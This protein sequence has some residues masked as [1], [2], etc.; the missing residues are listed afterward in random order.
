MK[1][2][3]AVILSTIILFY[4]FLMS[5]ITMDAAT[6]DPKTLQLNKGI[7]TIPIELGETHLFNFTAPETGYY[8]IETGGSAD[9][10]GKI[11]F[12]GV[13]LASDDDSG[14][15]MNC[16]ISYTASD[17]LNTLADSTVPKNILQ[18]M[19]YD[20]SVRENFLPNDALNAVQAGKK[21]G[22]SA[23]IFLFS[24]HG[25]PGSVRFTNTYVEEMC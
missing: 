24:G 5:P 9:T 4:T 15:G 1:K 2:K 19:G 23:E 22:F 12:K 10:Y 13:L 7:S 20:V 11:R 17:Q 3:I 14:Y 21:L 18:E 6:I 8:I 16:A 25:A